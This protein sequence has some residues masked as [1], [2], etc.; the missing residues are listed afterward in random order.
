MVL[1][2]GGA[3]GTTVA[4]GGFLFVSSGGVA[5]GTADHGVMDVVGGIASGTIVSSGAV[6]YAFLGATVINT[7]VSSGGAVLPGSGGVAIGT[8]ISSGG[9]IIFDPSGITSGTIVLS[10]GEEDVT[11][12][13]GSAIG[14]HCLHRRSPVRLLG[15]DRQRHDG[16]C[17]RRRGRIVRWRQQR[18]RQQR[19]LVDRVVGRQR[20]GGDCFERWHAGRRLRGEANGTVVSG[21][22]EIVSGSAGGTV[23][24]AGGSAVVSS[25]G[26][27]NAMVLNGGSATVMSGGAIS[28]ATISGGTLE[29]ASGGG[30]MSSTISFAGG[31][32]LMLDDTKFRGKVAGLDSPAE[33]IDLVAIAY[34]S[35]TTTLGY[36]GNTLS[37]TL[38]VTDGT[39][40]A[41]LAILGDHALA[42][43]TLADDGHGGT[44][45][46]DPPVDSSGHLATA[47]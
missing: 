37:G 43:F 19:R 31:G 45:V 20:G 13:N 29:I 10:G 44:L 28:G 33:T 22:L 42:N 39:H 2:G 21:G 5:N 23:V 30:V 3:S 7:I 4:S 8:I 18:N 27:A 47:H 15:R 34:H 46:S 16:P 40:T 25:G 35:G 32:T 38:T 41:R 12:P 1:S 24:D 26:T 17:R 11:Y 36:S 14:T 9:H 6:E